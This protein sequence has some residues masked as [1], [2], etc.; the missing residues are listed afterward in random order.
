MAGGELSKLNIIFISDRMKD[1]LGPGTQPVF[2]HREV[3]LQRS[4]N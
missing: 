3:V 2:L 1:T 4:I